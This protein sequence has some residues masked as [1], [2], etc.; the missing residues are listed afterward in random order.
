M[1]IHIRETVYSE[2]IEFKAMRMATADGQKNSN[3][4]D[5]E[6]QA[7]REMFLFLTVRKLKSVIDLE[8]I[9]RIFFKCPILKVYKK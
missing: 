4:R 2:E 7:K 6:K 3:L 9:F 1:N 8:F 5:S